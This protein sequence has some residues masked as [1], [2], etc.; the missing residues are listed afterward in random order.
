MSEAKNG[1]KVVV[2]GGAGFIGANLT[3]ELLQRGYEVGVI[4]NL[5][6]GRRENV[7]HGAS[8]DVVDVRNSEA[9]LPL[10]ESAAVVFHLAA[11]PRVEYS[12]QHP[13]ETHEVNVTGTLNVLAA[14]GKDT[15][16]V[17]ASSAAVYGEIDAPLL[18]ED[19]PVAPVSPYGLHEISASDTS[20]SQVA[21]TVKRR[22]R[23]AFQ[24]LWAGIRSRRPLCSRCRAI[25]ET[26]QRRETA[27]DS[28]RWITNQRFYSCPRHCR[29]AYSRRRESARRQG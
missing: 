2:T 22:S 28:R 27:H 15:R 11:L 8:L 25:P 14:A 21:Y 16:V 23:Y 20:R 29:S 9:L 17:L 7:P 4:D 19:M 18:S 1:K 26:A 5:V 10:L 12:I 3:R 13:L 24:C 6:A